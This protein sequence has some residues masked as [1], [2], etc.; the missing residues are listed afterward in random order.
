MGQL[1]AAVDEDGHLQ[2]KSLVGV[3]PQL[4]ILVH[5]QTQLRRVAPD[6]H[7]GG[8]RR[9]RR[10]QQAGNVRYHLGVRWLGPPNPLT[11]TL[12]GVPPPT[13]P[14]NIDLSSWSSARVFHISG[15]DPLRSGGC[16]YHSTNGGCWQMASVSIHG[17]KWT[18]RALPLARITGITTADGRSAETST[19]GPRTAACMGE[20]WGRAAPMSGLRGRRM[21]SLPKAPTWS[22]LMSAPARTA[23]SRRQTNRRVDVKGS[24]GARSMSGSSA[25]SR[26]SSLGDAPRRVAE[27]APAEQ[28]PPPSRRPSPKVGARSEPRPAGTFRYRKNGLQAAESLQ[29]GCHR[30]GCFVAPL[31]VHRRRDPLDVVRRCGGGH[32]RE[33]GLVDRAA[34][35]GHA[36]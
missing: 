24:S 17:L 34:H 1:G 26:S 13:S 18:P 22:R 10:A 15:E 4:C 21:W 5:C 9:A 8:L 12:P 32:S 30:G 11:P 2:P 29:Q 27:H 36:S 23:G 19:F 16:L 3:A 28:G 35:Q 20:G 7:R 6:P 33:V 25:A 14:V 31:Y